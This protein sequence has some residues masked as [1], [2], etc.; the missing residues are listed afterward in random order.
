M[1]YIFTLL[2]LLVSSFSEAAG[3]PQETLSARIKRAD[4]IATIT[5][6]PNA[7]PIKSNQNTTHTFEWLV[8]SNGAFKGSELVNIMQYTVKDM[9]LSD[10]QYVMSRL[11]NK[12]KYLVFMN[13]NKQ[14][15]TCDT[16]RLLTE[17]PLSELERE[18]IIATI[19]A[20]EY[21]SCAPYLCRDGTTYPSCNG[22]NQYITY[23]GEVCS[24]NKGI[25]GSVE[26]INVKYSDVDIDHPYKNAI[27]WAAENK[28]VNGYSD[29]TFKPNNSINRAEFLKVFLE[30]TQLL[31]KKNIPSAIEI[32]PCFIEY[33]VNDFL[34]TYPLT[35]VDFN[36]WYG[37]YLCNALRAQMV[38]GYPDGTFKPANTINA[39]EAAKIIVKHNS[40]GSVQ[41]GTGTDWYTPFISY[42]QVRN[43]FPSS[44]ESANDQLTRGEMVEMMWRLQKNK[45]VT[46]P[47]TTTA[48]ITTSLGVITVE[49]YPDTAPKAVENFV[50]HAKNGY[51]NG[52]RFHR[53]IADFMIQGGDP[54]G[55]G[56]GG[57]SI[58]GTSF[59]DEFIGDHTM[60][61]GTL[62][63]ANSGPNTNGSQFFIV[64]KKDGTPWLQ[65]KH[66]IFGKVTEGM[67]V[68][69]AIAN[70][71]KDAQDKP[72][73]D[74]TFTISVE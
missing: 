63:M 26:R 30:S 22:N 6:T 24:N 45:V 18:E 1:K 34:Q 11:Q 42:L 48:T 72:L 7:P 69:D 33:S 5:V 13:K 9:V 12:G 52:L 71:K 17:N 54:S 10:D 57:K 58:W 8:S 55:N 60:D 36:A 66:T 20:Q 46:V 23:T 43:A 32:A 39:A 44:I 38:T 41:Q 40:Q 49:L 28:I 62:A 53:V 2:L 31:V 51:Y 67:E 74:V 65:G 59:A 50:T 29:R 68:V 19:Y 56:T 61:Y 64:Q 27:T 37:I 70:S 35:D 25:M 3:C 47:V 15:A 14:I 73:Q 21:E 16:P 4:I